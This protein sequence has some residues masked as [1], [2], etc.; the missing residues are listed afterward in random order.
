MRYELDPSQGRFTVQAFAR[1]L[2]AGLGHSPRFAARAFGGALDFDPA[3]PAEASFQMTIRAD[4]LTLA[5]LVSPKDRAEIE[6]R[7]RQEVLQTA[8][9]PDI[10]FRSARV[11]ADRVAEGWY[12]LHIAGEL[13][14]HGVKKA[15]MVDTQARL[16]DD[17]A[18]L[19]GAF[20][21]SQSAYRI[22]RVTALGGLIN[23]QDELKCEFDLVGVK[24][25]GG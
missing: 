2:L 24:P 20:P 25:S 18:R 22:Q 19:S 9:Y 16:A 15:L 21:L 5:D 17:T 12:R 7:M 11:T 4:S 14:L 6:T 13:S 23:L 8:T 1:G 3:V 10:V